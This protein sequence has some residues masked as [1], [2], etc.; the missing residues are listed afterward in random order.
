MI[1][2]GDGGLMAVRRGK[3]WFTAFAAVAGCG[4]CVRRKEIVRVYGALDITGV[5]V[6]HHIFALGLQGA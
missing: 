2:V 5:L 1:V 3:Q 4:F 6:P